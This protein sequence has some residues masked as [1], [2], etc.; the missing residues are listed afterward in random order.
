M[1]SVVDIGLH[2]PSHGID[3]LLHKLNKT[4][5]T[6]GDDVKVRLEKCIECCNRV[7]MHGAVSK[8]KRLIDLLC[9]V[10]CREEERGPAN[11]KPLILI[12]V[13]YR[14]QN[15]AIC[16]V[17]AMVEDQGFKAC[18]GFVASGL[19]ELSRMRPKSK[20]CGSGCRTSDNNIHIT[21]SFFS[22]KHKVR[23]PHG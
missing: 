19:M 8:R 9:G 12:V 10:T 22:R 14:C 13:L 15:V 21:G 20:D 4:L 1:R 17:N 7:W 2:F 11:E 6:A 3:Q 16:A 23:P 18:M 5:I